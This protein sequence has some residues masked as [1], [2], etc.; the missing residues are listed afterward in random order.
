[1]ESNRESLVPLCPACHREMVLAHLKSPGL[2]DCVLC[3][4]ESD[5][6]LSKEPNLLFVDAWVCTVCG[7]VELHCSVDESDYS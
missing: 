1:M 3:L 5:D 4:E 7:H 6:L 2:G